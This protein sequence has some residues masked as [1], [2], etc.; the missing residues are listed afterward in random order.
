MTMFS[1]KTVRNINT[2]LRITGGFIIAGHVY[3]TVMLAVG[4]VFNKHIYELSFYSYFRVTMIAILVGIAVT[5]PELFI[6]PKIIER[7]NFMASLFFRTVLYLSFAAFALLIFTVVLYSV[8]LGIPPWEV[9]VHQEALDFLSGEFLVILLLC[10]IVAFIVNAVRLIVK[11][12]GEG[13]FWDYIT[14]KYHLP[15]EEERVFMFL[16]L[17]ASTTIAEKIGHRQ[18]HYFLNELFRD[19]SEPIWHNWGEVYQYVGDEVVITWDLKDG[20]HE[21]HCIRCFFEIQNVLRQESAK[22]EK[23][24]GFA[25]QFKAGIHAGKVIAGEVGD[26]KTEIVFH[27]DTVNTASRIRSECNIY[28]KDL[29]V[30]R[31]LLDLLPNDIKNQFESQFIGRIKLKGKEQEI[32]LYSVTEVRSIEHLSRSVLNRPHGSVPIL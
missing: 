26:L 12:F 28:Q 5:I 1:S 21:G 9:L 7:L 4:H 3:L 6:F 25:P 24:Y 22:Y 27:G 29:L 30:S 14:G 20:T 17:Y 18:Y 2:S 10:L 11:R 15:R 19:I 32:E 23:A 13:V 16:D 31:E 8:E